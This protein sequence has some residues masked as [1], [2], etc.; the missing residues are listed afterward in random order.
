METKITTAS[1]R[2][3]LSHNYSTFEVAVNL[4]NEN[5]ISIED[6]DNARK[7]SQLLATN[8]VNEYK[9]SAIQNPKIEIQ[10]IEKK[11]DELK[12]L[13]GNTDEV[14]DPKAVAEIQSLPAYID[15]KKAKK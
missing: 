1:V 11:L 4:E 3:A 10:R 14:V 2:I 13:T 5:G 15:T 8:A 12:K 7:Q 9:G 6:I